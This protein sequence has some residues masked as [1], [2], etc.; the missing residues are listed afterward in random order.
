[1]NMIVIGFNWRRLKYII[2]LIIV[3]ILASNAKAE[4]LGNYSSHDIQDE[5]LIVYT[6]TAAVSITPFTNHIVKIS[7]YPDGVVQPDSS[8][9]VVLE[10][11]NVVWNV[12][13]QDSMLVLTLSGLSVEVQKYPVR[14]RYISN[15]ITVLSDENGFFWDGDVR[16][17]RFRIAGNEHFYGG[18]ERAIDIDLRG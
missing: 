11:Q 7:L 5:H 14:L 17:N 1:M 9:V 12:T 16:G 13:V 4:F 3:L 2:S 10:P 15:G 8:V 18:G 6:Q